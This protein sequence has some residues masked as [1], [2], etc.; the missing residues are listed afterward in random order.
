MEKKNIIIRSLPV[1]FADSGGEGPPVLF[2]HGNSGGADSFEAQ[3]DLV[4]TAGCRALAPDL[5]G[6]GDSS[7]DPRASEN[8]RVYTVEY[9]A[10]FL[11]AFAE[12]A[13]VRTPLLVGHSL[14]GHIALHLAERMRVRGLMLLGTSPLED[15][16]DVQRAF[17]PLKETSV[18]FT[19]KKTVREAE[20]L[21]AVLFQE[22]SHRAAFMR[23]YL[24]AHGKVRENLGASLGPGAF[25]GDVSL[26]K[27]ISCPIHFC[28]GDRDPLLNRDYL[29]SLLTVSGREKDLS[30]LKDCGHFPQIEQP[31]LLNRLLGW[32]IRDHG[33][34]R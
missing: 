13:G 31:L 9:F 22:E 12:A 33:E 20:D 11:S 16:R 1:S 23:H 10:D 5:P 4:R 30:F 15:H 18:L 28:L 3:F 27:K 2:I 21:A 7:R 34:S 25:F 29:I 26:L 32:F 24:A 14:G 19:E 8:P 6:H 17:S